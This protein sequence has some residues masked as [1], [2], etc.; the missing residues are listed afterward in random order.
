MQ[1]GIVPIGKLMQMRRPVQRQIAVL[2]RRKV[3]P[4]R[5]AGDEADPA[6]IPRKAEITDTGPIPILLRA[7]IAVLQRPDVAVVY[8]ERRS[9]AAVHV[10]FPRT[11]SIIFY[12]VQTAVQG[13]HQ[14]GTCKVKDGSGRTESNRYGP[15]P[16]ESIKCLH[17]PGER[18]TPLYTD[19]DCIPLLV[20]LHPSDPAFSA[21]MPGSGT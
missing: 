15:I 18:G 19:R 9:G 4:I 11:A 2:V 1:Y 13:H 14:A 21:G 12:P 8:A 5:I 17:A 16:T 3:K 10:I 6:A 20:Q 7:H